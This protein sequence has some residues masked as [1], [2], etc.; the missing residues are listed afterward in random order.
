MIVTRYGHSPRHRS[1]IILP[2]NK[3]L[4]PTA[5]LA[6]NRQPSM[7]IVIVMYAAA[8]AGPLDPIL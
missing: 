4:Q 1:S 8:D 3:R 6:R 2:P 5:I 7:R